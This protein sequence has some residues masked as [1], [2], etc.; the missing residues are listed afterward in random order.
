M[1]FI[2]YFKAAQIGLKTNKTR[3][4]LTIL[5]I[6]IGISS[7][8]T[9]VSIGSGAQNIIIS[10]ISSIGPTNIFIEPGG[11]PKEMN[12]GNGFQ[13]M[14]EE[15]EITTLT[16]DDALVIEQDPLIK[17]IASFVMGVDK[18]IYGNKNKKITYMGM[19]TLGIDMF[20]AKIDMGINITDKDVK[21]MARKIVIGKQIKE[22][23]FG[24]EDPIGKT[25]RIQ[26]TNFRVIGVLE[27]KG[28][29]MF[30]NMDEAVYVP[31]TTAQKIL[32]G[33]D[34][35]R[36]IIARV[37]SE[38]KIDEAMHNIRLTLR[39]RHDIYN[40]EGDT[41]KD[42]FKITS[43]QETAEI[44]TTVTGVFAAF[45][46]SVAAIALVV[47]GIGI[48]NIMLVSVTERTR[49]IGLRKSVG[50]TKKDILSQF[51]IEAVNLTFLGGLIGI[52]FGFLVSFGIS[53]VLGRMLN[54]NWEFIFPLSSVVTSFVVSTLIGLVFGIYPARKA[55]E[56][57]PIEALRYE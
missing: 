32:L 20:D 45:L 44:L 31:L 10:Q 52:L 53:L 46:S 51:L 41:T 23:L 8:V 3:S 19:T 9:M 17:D 5:G 34:H 30:I 26:K 36:W 15:F 11:Q 49:E 57:S 56:L 29:Q 22:D 50:A 2:D 54:L 55:S 28:M 43:Q 14:L 4:F 18:V 37:V 1:K 33:Q 24:N 6:V 47:G 39:E 7:V 38:D 25:I 13:A 12:R 48:M 42:D 27:E 21:S 35:L 16:Q 40:P